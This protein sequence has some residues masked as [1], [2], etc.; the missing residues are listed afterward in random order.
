MIEFERD[1]FIAEFNTYLSG[2]DDGAISRALAMF[3]YDN[4]L[5]AASASSPMDREARRGWLQTLSDWALVAR[6]AGE[7]DPQDADD[8]TDPSGAGQRRYP[9][10]SQVASDERGGTPEADAV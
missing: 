10:W 9:D 7:L 8:V 2:T 3:G 5:D 6:D 4:D 1:E